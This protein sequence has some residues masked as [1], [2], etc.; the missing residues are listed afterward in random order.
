MPKGLTN[1]FLPGQ[2]IEKA[3]GG[4]ADLT[5]LENRVAALETGLATTNN[6]VTTTNNNVA[7]LANRVSLLESQIYTLTERTDRQD[8]RLDALEGAATSDRVELKDLKARLSALT[9]R[10]HKT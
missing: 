6:N 8:L 9:S 3:S 7:G 10:T 4:T 5:D 2:R 1:A